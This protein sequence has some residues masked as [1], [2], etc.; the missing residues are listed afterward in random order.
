MTDRASIKLWR[1]ETVRALATA[2]EYEGEKNAKAR[3]VAEDLIGRLA[4][5]FPIV[6]GK[7]E[8]KKRLYNQVLLPAAELATKIN[9]SLSTYSLA[10]E[11]RHPFQSRVLLADH[12]EVYRLVDIRTRKTLKPESGVTADRK[13]RIGTVIM[14]LEPALSR[15][16][17]DGKRVELRPDTLLIQL[18]YPLKKRGHG[19]R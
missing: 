3:E 6:R 19:S 17:T 13:G 14:P 15:V 4:D 9:G 11:I 12:L 16:N 1:S 10:M 18:I 7:H 8:S 5:F 2:N